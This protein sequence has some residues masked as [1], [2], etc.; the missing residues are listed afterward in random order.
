MAGLRR[1]QWALRSA[2][3]VQRNAGKT[4]NVFY[5]GLRLL[6]SIC[7]S[8]MAEGVLMGRLSQSVITMASG[9]TR[10]CHV[11]W[12]L[13]QERPWPCVRQMWRTPALRGSPTAV[14]KSLQKLHKGN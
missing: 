3:P 5:P 11:L 1:G 4:S 6:Q 14:R 9:K 13:Q 10:S 7:S 8:H 2:Q 12:S